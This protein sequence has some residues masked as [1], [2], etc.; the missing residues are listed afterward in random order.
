MHLQEHVEPEGLGFTRQF[1]LAIGQTNLLRSFG[2]TSG[3][4]SLQKDLIMS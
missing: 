4:N 3:R 2:D 1:Q